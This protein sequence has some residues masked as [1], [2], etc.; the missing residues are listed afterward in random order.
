MS[1]TTGGKLAQSHTRRW[2]RSS[3]VKRPRPGDDGEQ[4]VVAYVPSCLWRPYPW[5][6][7]RAGSRWEGRKEAAMAGGCGG[8]GGGESSS[9]GWDGG[10]GGGRG[11]REE[12]E[13]MLGWVGLGRWWWASIGL[14]FSGPI[15]SLFPTLSPLRFLYSKWFLFCTT[16][17]YG[18]VGK[19]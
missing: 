18:Q 8:G 9:V 16:H 12:E 4:E 11:T 3:E 2:R 15:P 14:I 13:Q 1:W 17:G 6:R 5:W 19:A 7:V 10:D